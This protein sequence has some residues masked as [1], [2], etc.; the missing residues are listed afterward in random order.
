[1]D[2]YVGE[3]IVI[4]DNQSPSYRLKSVIFEDLLR[5]ERT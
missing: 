4:V 5:M 1:M 2:E 3:R